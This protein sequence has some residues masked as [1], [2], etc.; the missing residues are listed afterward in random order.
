MNSDHININSEIMVGNVLISKEPH[1]LKTLYFPNNKMF[2][3]FT[4]P[5]DIDNYYR[6]TSFYKCSNSEKLL[7]EYYEK[8]GSYDGSKKSWR[9]KVDENTSFYS[10]SKHRKYGVEMVRYISK[11]DMDNLI[12]RNDAKDDEIIDSK[13]MQLIDAYYHARVVE[14][15]LIYTYGGKFTRFNGL[16]VNK[17]PIVFDE[18]YSD[19]CKMFERL[20]KSIPQIEYESYISDDYS[21][22]YFIV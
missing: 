9:V 18:R 12:R 10:T 15:P 1:H 4:C 7:N 2:K 17:H 6:C 20:F 22:C 8:F 11:K 19:T 14:E 21:R 3:K 5:L 13:K 16:K